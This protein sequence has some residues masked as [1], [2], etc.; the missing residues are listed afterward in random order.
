MV[1]TTA[2][3]FFT[4]SYSHKERSAPASSRDKRMN[5]SKQSERSSQHQKRR[6]DPCVPV[7]YP[8]ETNYKGC[9]DEETAG[10]K[11]IAHS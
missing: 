7:V 11:I 4:P 3:H 8:R 6:L 5:Q 1:T 10:V 9:Y 2:L